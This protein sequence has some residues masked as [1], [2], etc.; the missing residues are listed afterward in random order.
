MSCD[1]RQVLFLLEGLV[2]FCEE[3]LFI[4]KCRVVT[5]VQVVWSETLPPWR[6]DCWPPHLFG[7]N[8]SP[9]LHKFICI[10]FPEQLNKSLKLGSPRADSHF[11]CENV[12][13]G[14]KFAQKCSHKQNASV[15]CVTPQRTTSGGCVRVCTL[16]THV[17]HNSTHR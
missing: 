12:F 8:S 11:S 17:S 4:L 10:Y 6:V 9:G 14:L 15:V 3:A 2:P 13:V 5:L 1:R 7:W 16:E